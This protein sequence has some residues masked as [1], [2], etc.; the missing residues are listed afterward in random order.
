MTAT[1]EVTQGGTG[2]GAGRVVAAEGQRGVRRRVLGMLPAALDQT[3]VGT[4]LPTIVGD[5]GG[6]GTCRGW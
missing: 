1:A 3:I 2:R 5:L 4:A 6:A